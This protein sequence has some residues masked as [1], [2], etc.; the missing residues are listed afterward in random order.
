MLRGPL[1]IR[2]AVCQVLL[3][4]LSACQDKPIEPTAQDV[5]RAEQLR[6]TDARLAAIYERSCLACHGTRS[7]APLAGFEPAWRTRLE[8]GMTTLLS[9]AREGFNGMPA[10]GLCSDCSD[11]DLLALIQFMSQPDAH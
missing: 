6:P 10:K 3:T 4:L 8:Q 2:F 7:A 5:Q 1:L 9:H 11:E